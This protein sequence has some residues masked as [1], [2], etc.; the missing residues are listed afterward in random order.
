MPSHLTLIL[1]GARSGKSIHAERLAAAENRP[2]HF[3][4]TFNPA[5]CPDDS[6]MAERV[7]VHRSRRPD[8]WITHEPAHANLIETIQ[9]LGKS[10]ILI[11]C[12]TLWLSGIL[13]TETAESAI[14][15]ID[16]LC[17]T[18]IQS[19]AHILCVS[20]ELGLAPVPSNPLARDFRDLHGVMNQRL[21]HLAH[22]VEWVLAGIPLRIKPAR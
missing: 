1:G 10:L 16:A 8:S 4:P 18:L 22:T 5:L 13:A 6:S 20:N 2:V 12:M 3:L 11:D 7:N 14:P 9:H 17:A 21:A 15:Q 19:P